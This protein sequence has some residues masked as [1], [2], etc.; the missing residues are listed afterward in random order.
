MFSSMA[1]DD[2]PPAAAV[3][4]RREPLPGSSSYYDSKEDLLNNL[5]KLQNNFLRLR[6]SISINQDDQ[7]T[8][9]FWTKI[10]S[11][12]VNLCK[13][14]LQPVQEKFIGVWL[15]KKGEA[16]AVKLNPQFTD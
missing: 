10:N 6:D 2:V 11:H 15:Q 8:A 7:G 4:E 12:I 5:E 14:A 13:N 3:P 16:I 9:T 1:T